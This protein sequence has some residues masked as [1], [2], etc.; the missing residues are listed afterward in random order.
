MGI[1]DRLYNA[2]TY[3]LIAK[4]EYEYDM[5]EVFRD[6]MDTVLKGMVVLDSDRETVEPDPFKS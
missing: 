4:G 5:S 1:L 3:A 6:N 2:K